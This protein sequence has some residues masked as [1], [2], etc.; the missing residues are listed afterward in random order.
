MDCKNKIF[1][2]NNTTSN[3][4]NSYIHWL[5]LKFSDS[6]KTLYNAKK[7]KSKLMAEL[8]QIPHDIFCPSL[9]LR[10]FLEFY[11][12]VRI[13]STIVSINKQLKTKNRGQLCFM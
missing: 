13:Y 2:N 3:N 11:L 8:I 7:L 1:I 4:F 12:R 9:N 10:W 6:I 5:E